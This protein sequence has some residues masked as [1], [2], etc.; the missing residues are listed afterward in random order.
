MRGG[1]GVAYTLN[2]RDYK[3]VMVIVIS[4]EDRPSDGEQPSRELLRTGCIFGYA[5]N[6]EGQ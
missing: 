6:G 1:G 3:G 2:C 4:D 5:D